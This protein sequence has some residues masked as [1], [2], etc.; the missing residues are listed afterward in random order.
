MM[1]EDAGWIIIDRTVC[2]YIFASYKGVFNNENKLLN[3]QVWD[4]NL[5]L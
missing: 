5:L 3:D 1:K 4:L 2:I